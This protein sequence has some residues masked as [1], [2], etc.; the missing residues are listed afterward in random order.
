MLIYLKDFFIVLGMLVSMCCFYH[1]FN[2]VLVF[3][4]CTFTAWLYSGT[5]LVL[6]VCLH[7]TIMSHN[8]NW[9]VLVTLIT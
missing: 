5:W 9:N 6:H 4:F 7:H 8:G 2:N 3:F 1:P